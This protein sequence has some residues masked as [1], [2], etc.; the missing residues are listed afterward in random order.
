MIE[1]SCLKYSS[2]VVE[3]S[4]QLGGSFFY[5]IF[6]DKISDS[7]HVKQLIRNQYGYFVLRK[8]LLT[9]KD[10]NKKKVVKKLISSNLKVL[11]NVELIEKWNDMLSETQFSYPK[12]YKNQQE[13]DEISQDNGYIYRN[14]DNNPQAN[15]SLN[16]VQKSASKT[17]YRHDN[18]K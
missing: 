9:L 12:H 14:F 15:K 1:L 10:Q 7:K 16:H 4:L 6:I 8:C 3:K 11:N 13:E 5:K 2:S 18:L 17:F